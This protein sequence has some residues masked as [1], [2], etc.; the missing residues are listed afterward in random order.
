MTNITQEKHQSLNL[1]MQLAHGWRSTQD[2]YLM[3]NLLKIAEGNNL[4]V[5]PS[6]QRA[7][8]SKKE[9]SPA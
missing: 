8:Q 4:K 9:L 2:P 7:K 3:K 5:S 1:L 6:Y